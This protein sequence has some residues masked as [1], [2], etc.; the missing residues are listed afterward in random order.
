MRLAVLSVALIGGV[1]HFGCNGSPAEEPCADCEPTVLLAQQ[2]LPP[3]IIAPAPPTPA[4][5]PQDGDAFSQEISGTNFTVTVTDLSPGIYF[6]RIGLNEVDYSGPGQR[7]FDI[8]CGTNVIARNLDIFATAG[9][10]GKVCFV[11]GRV[12]RL[13]DALYGPLAFTFT[14]RTNAAKMNS[15]EVLDESGRSLVFIRAADLIDSDD[16]SALQVPDVA[17]P[18]YWK[19]PSKPLKLRVDD[20]VRRLSLAE[21]VQQMRNAAPAI[22]RLGLPAYNYWNECLHGVARAG[23]AT[24]FP[25]AIGMAATW[26]LSAPP[27]NRRCHRHRSPRQTQRLH[28]QTRR[29]QRHLLRPHLLDA[30]HQHLP[31]PALGPRTGNLRRRPLPHRAPGRRLHPRSPGR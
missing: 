8:T 20:L 13:D 1:I 12:D 18:E 5:P 17:G 27:P 3:Q 4:T 24:V 25:Q 28:L 30:Q 7:I 9:G 15:L 6:V 14:S 23:I 11:T 29:Q 31:R 16:P 22:P 10:A 19:D 2:S 26:D 21:K